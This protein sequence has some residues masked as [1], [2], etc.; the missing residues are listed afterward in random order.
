MYR[1]FSTSKRERIKVD[2]VKLSSKLLAAV[3]AARLG[4]SV[5]P[6]GDGCEGWEE[7]GRGVKK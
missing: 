6:T 5:Y 2:S 3:V 4:N 1:S 7:V